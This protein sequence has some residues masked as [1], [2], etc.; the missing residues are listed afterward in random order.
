MSKNVDVS[1][2]LAAE[3]LDRIAT[4]DQNIRFQTREAG[5]LE[6]AAT[7]AN[8]T[9]VRLGVLRADYAKV[10]AA[11]GFEAQP[12]RSPSLTSFSK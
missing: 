7:S 3:L 10:L 2:E 11:T 1:S 4:L 12:F 5:R 9:A 6:A 8:E